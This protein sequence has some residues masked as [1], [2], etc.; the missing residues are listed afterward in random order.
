MVEEIMSI[1]IEEL[2]NIKCPF[3]V[4]IDYKIGKKKGTPNKN[5]IAH[6][7]GFSENDPLGVGGGLFPNFSVVHFKNGGWLLVEHLMK[8][9]SIVEQGES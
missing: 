2:R 7:V 5:N 4:A 9:Y 6:I 1:D 3:K 8:Y